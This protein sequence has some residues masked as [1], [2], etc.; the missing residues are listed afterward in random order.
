MAGV[1]DPPIP[2]LAKPPYQASIVS[3]ELGKSLAQVGEPKWVSITHRAGTPPPHMG[4]RR[5]RR[6]APSRGITKADEA[7]LERIG[8]ERIGSHKGDCGVRSAGSQACR[9]STPSI[10]RPA[11]VLRESD[12]FRLGGSLREPLRLLT[13]LSVQAPCLTVS[14]V[15][16]RVGLE[17]TTQGL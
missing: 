12:V 14:P 11:G 4:T 6:T 8:L 10:P 2:P 17:P 9:D 1:G 16:G 5:Q 15:V 3:P 7:I 13:Q